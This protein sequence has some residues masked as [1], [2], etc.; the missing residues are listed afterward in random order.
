MSERKYTYKVE[1]DTSSLAAAE[2]E[3]KRRMSGAMAQIDS[4]SAIR[5]IDPRAVTSPRSSASITQQERAL[6]ATHI[7]TEKRMTAETRAEAKAREAATRA[8]SV[9][10]IEAARMLRTRATEEERRLTAEVRSQAYERTRAAAQGPTVGNRLM[11][12]AANQVASAA[13]GAVSIYG[14]M[15]AGREVYAMGKQGAA[16]KQLAESFDKLTESVGLSGNALTQKLGRALAGT[17]SDM[18]L[19]SE[20]NRLLLTAQNE[21][22]TIT[23]K[24]I[25]TLGRFSRLRATQLTANG[26]PL[27]ADEAYSRLITG[28]TK[29]EMELLDELGISSKGLAAQLGVDVQDVNSSVESLLTAITRVAEAELRSVGDPLLSDAEKIQKAETD[30]A[31]AMDRLRAAAIEPVVFSVEVAAKT[32]EEGIGAF[33]GLGAV[34]DR[35]F[36]DPKTGLINMLR[37]SGATPFFGT[38]VSGFREVTAEAE[39]LKEAYNQ[40]R[41]AEQAALRDNPVSLGS[42]GGQELSAV[43]ELVRNLTDAY[44]KLE[45]KTQAGAFDPAGL[46][47]ADQEWQNI[48]RGI[49]DGTLSIDEANARLA[50]MVGLLGQIAPLIGPAMMGA[51]QGVGSW[52]DGVMQ[53]F[54]TNARTRQ[55]LAGDV[56]PGD[57]TEGERGYRLAVGDLTEKIAIYEDLTTKARGAGDL[58]KFYQLMATLT[59]LK[60]QEA[61]D[62]QSGIDKVKDRIVS[63]QEKLADAQFRYQV[64][65][66]DLTGQIALYQKQLAGLSE[67]SVEYLNTKMQIGSLEK[68]LANEQVSAAKRVEG[69]WAAAAEKTAAAFESAI[70]KVPGLFGTSPVTQ[71][72]MDRA[73]AGMPQRFPDSF[74]REMEDQVLNKNDQGINVQ[75]VAKQAGIDPSLPEKLIVQIFRDMWDSSELFANPENISRFVDMDAAREALAKQGRE[76]QG[77]ENLM[78][79]LQGQAGS[80]GFGAGTPDNLDAFLNQLTGE[81]GAATQINKSMAEATAGVGDMGRL[82]LAQFNESNSLTQF[83]EIGKLSAGETF[84]GWSENIGGAPFAVAMA[85]SIKQSIIDEFREV[86]NGGA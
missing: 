85:E 66:E 39:G 48:T 43:T 42:S 32:T 82:A 7:E 5:R 41:A 26:K 63:E 34:A 8:E 12:S 75:E 30:I 53:D 44:V 65:T 25:E 16:N 54:A 50:L 24:Q 4:T 68:Q 69:E 47:Q 1:V 3:I 35:L 73:A 9:E 45:E 59:S 64:S 49:Q 33:E 18:R 58:D 17:V 81:D 56:S 60:E 37:D 21:G 22:I 31:N 20:T 79:L 62:K 36:N 74:L 70:R 10:R 19:M 57:M 23:E 71:S 78:R 27:G 72:Q 52:A 2:A 55:V 14:A 76:T 38:F 46:A 40:I 6:L 67:G 83:Y 61:T 11:T 28:V 77:E 29:R 84:R 13:L 86:F 80:F 51:A 15:Q